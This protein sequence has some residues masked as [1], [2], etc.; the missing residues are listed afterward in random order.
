MLQRHPKGAILTVLSPFSVSCQ[1]KTAT[2]LRLT[3]FLRASDSNP[4]SSKGQVRPSTAVRETMQD[5]IWQP[6]RCNGSARPMQKRHHSLSD[7]KH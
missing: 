6:T 3:S 1:G 2:G 5:A 7:D 4:V